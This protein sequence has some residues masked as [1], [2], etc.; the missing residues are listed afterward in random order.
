M[1]AVQGRPSLG[2]TASRGAVVTFGGQLVRITIQLLGI[3]LLA[4]MLSP[5]DYGVT[6]MVLAIIGVGEILRDFGL[7]SAAIQAKTLSAGQR[8]NLFWI[9]VGIGAAL[10]AIV[11]AL[12]HPVANFYDDER[13]VPVAIALS[14]TFLLNGFSTQFHADLN[15]SFR[16]GTLATIEVASQAV[17]LVAALGCAALGW[18]YWAI[19][20][21]QLLQVL[22]QAVALPILGGWWPGMPKRGEQMKPLLAFGGGLVGAQILNYASRNVDSIVIGKVFG[23]QSLGYYN[24]AFQ[25][26][27]LP[28]NQINAPST[29][30]AL[31]TLSRLQDQPAR[32]GEFISFGQTV[33]LNIVSLVLGFSVAQATDVI[34]VAL[35]PQWAPT[36]PLFQILA[37]AGFFQAAAFA[38]YWVF[39]SQG[40]TTPYLW[41]TV[42]TRPFVIAAIS[43]GALWGV[44]GVAFA[45]LISTA[46][47]WPIGILWL[48]GR[49]T[50]PLLR[51]FLNGMRTL[52]VYGVA[53]VASYASTLLLPEAS[54]FLRI[55][56][57]LAVFVATVA[58]I[59]LCFPAFRRD[60]RSI[61]A[62]RRL[63]ARSRPT[64]AAD[65][66]PTEDPA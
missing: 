38:T 30:V 28:L 18:G 35:G 47:L 33:L 16:F 3:V 50:A 14:S 64:A 36:V 51:L 48:R 21:Q 45:Y 29:R 65:S 20:V 62:A 10:T 27:L 17:A 23:A 54:P 66:D 46:L 59:A 4:R 2:R 42:W 9:N 39:L 49:S 43:L 61:V 55:G 13:L 57:G 44:Q 19:V 31:P 8:A 7:S 37:V 22:L 60:I 12:A 25:L 63:L 1:T 52:T 58:L 56:V 6:A 5:T 32:F 24:R 11:A 53:A 26:M 15:R 34:A 41:Y 40:L